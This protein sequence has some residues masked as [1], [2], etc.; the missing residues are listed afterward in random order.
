MTKLKQIGA[1]NDVPNSSGTEP[2]GA[3]LNILGRTHQTVY[4]KNLPTYLTTT[5]HPDWLTYSNFLKWYL[6]NK[7]TGNNVDKDLIGA[8]EYGTDTLCGYIAST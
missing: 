5:I 7:A 1:V 2:Y 3:W 6:D 4:K 8:N